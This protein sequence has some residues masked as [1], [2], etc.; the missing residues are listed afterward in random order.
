M[1]IA[2]SASTTGDRETTGVLESVGDDEAVFTPNSEP[3]TYVVRVTAIDADGVWAADSV[4]FT[5]GGSLG[6]VVTADKGCGCG[7]DRHSSGAD[8]IGRPRAWWRITVP[9]CLD[10]HQSDRGVGQ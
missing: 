5:V 8:P 6:A 7:P 1:A 3:A 10:G 9:V 2:W 4:V